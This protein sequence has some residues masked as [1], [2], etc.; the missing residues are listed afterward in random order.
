MNSKDTRALHQLFKLWQF[1]WSSPTPISFINQQWG[2]ELIQAERIKNTAQTHLNWAAA[3]RETLQSLGLQQLDR[4]Q[5][6]WKLCVL[7]C[8]RRATPPSHFGWV[9]YYWQEIRRLSSFRIKSD[10]LRPKRRLTDLRPCWELAEILNAV[11]SGL[12]CA[13]SG[14]LSLDL[15][16]GPGPFLCL[17]GISHPTNDRPE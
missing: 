11:R 1:S 10:S 9:F 6:S 2:S 12:I 5:S 15:N 3:G 17:R 8:A 14:A 4:Y 16:P 13:T 7:A